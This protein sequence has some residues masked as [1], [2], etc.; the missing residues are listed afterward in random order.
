MPAPATAP[1]HLLIDGAALA[2]PPGTAQPPWP[3]L[4][5]LQALQGRLQAAATLEVD[6]DSLATPFDIALARAHGLPDAPGQTP[7]AAFETGTLGTPCAW[8]TPCHWQAGMDHITVLDPA[9]LQLTEAESR[10]LLAAVQPLLSADGLAVRYVRADAWLAQGELLR[11]LAT[12]SL[13]RALQ[14]PL[15][16]DDLARAPA[17]AQGAQ[18]RRLQSELQM[19]LYTQPVND[20]R[21]SARRWPVNALWLHGAGQLDAPHPP[22]PQVLAERRLADP[23]AQTS[24][25]AWAQA[26]QT[27]DADGGARLQAAA[28]GG[29]PVQLTLCGPQRAITLA[30]RAGWWANMM[31]KMHPQRLSDL[32]DQL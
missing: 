3:D 9:E 5:H 26:W 30:S 22:R 25:A 19:L 32:R 6:D 1:L 17:A 24:A 16:P 8:L 11:G 13:A 12:A 18:L 21:E 28:Q 10:A 7:W 20:A 31:N 29:Q 2:L 27:I 23:A 4:P 15:A 14:H